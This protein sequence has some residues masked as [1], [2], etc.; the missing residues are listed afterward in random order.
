MEIDFRY[1]LDARKDALFIA[2]GPRESIWLQRFQPGD[3]IVCCHE[4]RK[5]F[6]SED[7]RDK[8]PL[9]DSAEPLYFLRA[10]QLLLRERSRR[11]DS[12]LEYPLRAL[13]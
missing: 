4:C 12:V 6:Y 13:R 3:E 11:D 9:C 7:W 2:Y 10:N 1:T 8:C 5:V